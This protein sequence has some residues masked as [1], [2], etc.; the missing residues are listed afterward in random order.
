M[1]YDVTCIIPVKNGEKTIERAVLSAFEAGC[2][3]VSAYDDGSTD[4]TGEIIRKLQQKQWE[5][6]DKAPH[7]EG[8]LYPSN[9]WAVPDV[10]YTPFV[11]YS[12]GG[13]FSYGV[14]FARNFLISQAPWGLII[15]LDADDELIDVRPLVEAYED[16]SWIYGDY[17]QDDRGNR[18]RINGFATGT[19]PRRNIT[20]VSFLFHKQ[21]WLKVGGFDPDFAYAEDYAFQC[22]LTNAGVKP[23]YTPH[24]IYQRH[25]NDGQNE[26]TAMANLYWI[27]YR[28]MCRA[29]YPNVFK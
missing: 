11:K 3:Y 13:D 28:D 22:A 25:L 2:K 23:I 14:N 1:S 19:L 7:E 10:L 29:K 6:K 21:D 4:G 26:R 18:S 27:F 20:G 8:V 5:A 15:C 12:K 16:G 17:I 24:L 9:L